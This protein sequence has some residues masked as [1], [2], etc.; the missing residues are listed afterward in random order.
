MASNIILLLATVTLAAA[1]S[2]PYHSETV[3]GQ[4]KEFVEKYGRNYES[5]LE[6]AFR[7]GIFLKTL[8]IIDHLNKHSD[9]AKFG[10]TINILIV[11]QTT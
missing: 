7:F 10:K 2:L 1:K 6:E 8:D 4:F 11:I 5:E 9:N 3:I